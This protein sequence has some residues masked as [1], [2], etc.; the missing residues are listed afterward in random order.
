MGIAIAAGVIGG[1]VVAAVIIGVALAFLR[2]RTL[3]VELGDRKTLYLVEGIVLA[4][5]L[6][7]TLAYNV[8]HFGSKPPYGALNDL[9]LAAAC[10]T[11]TPLALGTLLLAA[12]TMSG[13]PRSV[14]VNHR[15]GIGAYV[16]HFFMPLAG[17]IWLFSVLPR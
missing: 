1:W 10:V 9:I 13:N 17:P 6:A 16:A 12:S 11:L 7:F 15:I 3:P 2:K 14:A 4:L 5:A 8:M